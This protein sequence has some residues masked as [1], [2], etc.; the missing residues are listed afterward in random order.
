[1]AVGE[2]LLATGGP[3][4]WDMSVKGTGE[5]CMIVGGV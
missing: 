4:V 5:A 2:E 3:Q 1:M